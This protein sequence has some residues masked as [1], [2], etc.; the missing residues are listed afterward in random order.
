MTRPEEGLLPL[1]SKAA[2]AAFSAFIFSKFGESVGA[3]NLSSVGFSLLVAFG[4]C[5]FRL[6]EAF[7]ASSLSSILGCPGDCGRTA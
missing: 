7:V 3:S 1:A 4:R 6:E 2:G 5:H